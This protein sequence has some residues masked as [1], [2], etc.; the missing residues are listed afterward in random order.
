MAPAGPALVSTPSAS[1]PETMRSTSQPLPAPTQK[2]FI[3]SI[4]QHH[5]IQT[6]IGGH[7]RCG[8]SQGMRTGGLAVLGRA[9]VTS[10]LTVVG[11][12]GLGWPLVQL[13]S[14]HYNP[15]CCSA[16]ACHQPSLKILFNNRA[17][18][19]QPRQA[20]NPKD[21]FCNNSAWC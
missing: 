7:C 9:L 8:L 11:L 5:E 6:P 17:P 14:T 10:S 3:E 1:K 12:V 20:E 2:A 21:T 15:L 13:T 18:P 16:P 4:K 19:P